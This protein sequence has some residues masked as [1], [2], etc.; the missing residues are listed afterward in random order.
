MEQLLNELPEGLA[1]PTRGSKGSQYNGIYELM[2]KA[3]KGQLFEVTKELGYN[4]ERD[5]KHNKT[6]ILSCI[7]KQDTLKGYKVCGI[8]P[9]DSERLFI[10]ILEVPAAIIP[11]AKKEVIAEPKIAQQLKAGAKAE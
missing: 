9:Q 4:E 11:E 2:S 8:I 5:G 10:K 3:Q 1:M 7:G 6:N